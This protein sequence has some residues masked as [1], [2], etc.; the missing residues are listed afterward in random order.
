[1]IVTPPLRGLGLTSG[2]WYVLPSL[3]GFILVVVFYALIAW[4]IAWMAQRLFGRRKD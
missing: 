3:P 1:L 2:E 4:E